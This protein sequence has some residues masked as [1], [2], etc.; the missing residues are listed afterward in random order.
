MWVKGQDV[1]REGEEEIPTMYFDLLLPRIKQAHAGLKVYEG[2]QSA[3]DVIFLPADWWH[4][5]LNIQ[6][7]VAVTQNHCGPDNFD[8]VWRKIRRVNE[9]TAYLW[10]RNM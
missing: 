6:D 8:R 2:I 3:G 5:T 1:I 9:K 4:G 7:C 10:L